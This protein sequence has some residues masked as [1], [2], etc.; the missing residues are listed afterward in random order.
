[1]LRIMRANLGIGL[2][3][4]QVGIDGRVF[5]FYNK[6]QQTIIWNEDI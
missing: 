4:N 3:A 2:S 6:Q 5:V 1:M